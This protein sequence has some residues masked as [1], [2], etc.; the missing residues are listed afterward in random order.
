MFVNKQEDSENYNDKKIANYIPKSN[1]IDSDNSKPTFAT[2]TKKK[3]EGNKKE[4]MSK[5]LS[6][7]L[8]LISKLL[9]LA[10]LLTMRMSCHREKDQWQN[11]EDKGLN[12]ANKYFQAEENVYQQ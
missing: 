5:Q 3:E 12:K 7:F 1:A 11:K 2:T 8:F 4:E 6:V 10:V 9:M